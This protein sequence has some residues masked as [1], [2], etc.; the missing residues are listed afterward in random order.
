[1][2]KKARSRSASF[3]RLNISVPTWGFMVRR[4]RRV[5]SQK[6]RRKRSEAVDFSLGRSTYWWRATETQSG[7]RRTCHHNTKTIRT[8]DAIKI[9]PGEG[10]HT[11]MR[12]RRSIFAGGLGRRIST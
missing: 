10:E 6:S 2:E 9:R 4:S 7:E 12:E 3:L 1:M 5:N 8:G 11:A